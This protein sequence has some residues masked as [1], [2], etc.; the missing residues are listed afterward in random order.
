M[1]SLL[2]SG[3]PILEAIETT[4]DTVGSSEL[5][6]ALLRVSREGI[7]KGLTVG[8]AFRRETA[9]PRVVVN[10]IAIAEKSGHMEEVLETL[11]SF[12]SSESDNTL[13]TLVSLLEPILLIFI[14]LVVAVIALSIIV[15]VLQLVRQI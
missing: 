1:A 11:S 8:E 2:R 14:G 15:P 12:Y 3:T 5:K 7:A 9:F 13:K 4:A 6:A 10:L